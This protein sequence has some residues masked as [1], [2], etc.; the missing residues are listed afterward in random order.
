VLILLRSALTRVRV[1]VLLAIC[2]GVV[3]FGIWMA[4]QHIGLGINVVNRFLWFE[5]RRESLIEADEPHWHRLGG[6]RALEPVSE[7]KP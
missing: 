1:E 2:A 5:P 7:P 3:V 6:E 4:E